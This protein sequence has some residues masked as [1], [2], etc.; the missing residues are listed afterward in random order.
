MDLQ[1]MMKEE[2]HT[3]CVLC[4][5]VVLNVDTNMHE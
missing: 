5:E 4:L 2:L 3:V 1:A